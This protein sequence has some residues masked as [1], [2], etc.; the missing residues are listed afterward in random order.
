MLPYFIGYENE[1]IFELPS[2][3]VMVEDDFIYELPKSRDRNE[4]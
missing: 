4:D 2:A 3:T 1:N